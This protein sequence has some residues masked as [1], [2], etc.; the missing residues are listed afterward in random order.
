VSPVEVAGGELPEASTGSLAG[1][2]ERPRKAAAPSVGHR[3]HL[4]G[5]LGRQLDARA[6]GGK[7]ALARFTDGFDGGA[8]E[9]HGRLRRWGVGLREHYASML[10]G[11]APMAA[12]RSPG[13]FL[14]AYLTADRRRASIRL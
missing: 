3:R 6:A 8:G 9:V 14:I 1:V 4:P 12:S 13:S 7:R 5:V 10:G 11:H 2:D